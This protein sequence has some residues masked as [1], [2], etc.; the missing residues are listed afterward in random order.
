MTTYTAIT[1][2]QIDQDS[3]I[4]QPLM[5]AMRDNPIAITEG[6]TGAP[7]ILGLAAATIDEVQVLTVSAADTYNLGAAQGFVSGTVQTGGTSYVIGFTIN[8][9]GVTGSAR[10]TCGHRNLISGGSTVDMQL[11]K[12]D[13]VVATWTTGSTTEVLRSVDVSI[14]PGDQLI[15]Q[16]KITSGGAI[17]L[18][19][20]QKSTASDG[21]AD[22][23]L[24]IPESDL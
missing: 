23:S 8:I 22:V 12:N 19:S 15:W 11:L 5:T 13:S 6:A 16:H 4:T 17:S 20:G 2:G 9:E 18:L 10:F 3:P 14:V 1:N 7:R 24:L 21:Y